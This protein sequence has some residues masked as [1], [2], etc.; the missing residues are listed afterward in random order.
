MQVVQEERNFII[1]FPGSYHC[2][3]NHGVNCAEAVNFAPAD[4]MRYCHASTQRYRMYRKPPV[5][6]RH[7]AHAFWF[8]HSAHLNLVN[9][10]IVYP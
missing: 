2:G 1:T 7:T 3:F 10:L 9:G 5:G 6:T 8:C 4:W